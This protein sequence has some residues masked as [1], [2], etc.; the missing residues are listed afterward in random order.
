MS[1]T[2]RL[3][4]TKR[5]LPLFI[6]ISLALKITHGQVGTLANWR[7]VSREPEYVKL[8]REVLYYLKAVDEYERTPVHHPLFFLKKVLH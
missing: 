3:S 5:R 6:N 4:K 7:K 1:R 2:Q 8:D